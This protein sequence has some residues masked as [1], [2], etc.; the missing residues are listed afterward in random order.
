MTQV[1]LGNCTSSSREDST[2]TRYQDPALLQRLLRSDARK[3]KELEE[4][5]TKFKKL[6]AAKREMVSAV[7]PGCVGASDRIWTPQCGRMDL[8]ATEADAGRPA[9]VAQPQSPGAGQ[10]AVMHQSHGQA[11]CAHRSATSASGKSG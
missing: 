5:N 11:S 10:R 2:V 9:A 8:L 6:L 3:L 1:K 4:E 7:R